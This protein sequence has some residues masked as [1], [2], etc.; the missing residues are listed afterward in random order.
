MKIQE[1]EYRTGLE[2]PSVRFYEK[3]GLLTPKRLENGYRDYS[4]E[5]VE[6]LKKIKLLRRLGMSIEDIRKLQQ[7]SEDLSSAIV[8]QS[9]FHTSQIEDHRRCLAVCNAIREDGAEFSSLDAEHYLTLLREIKI[10]D[11][12]LGRT[13]FQEDVPKELH[14]WRRYF[15][16]CLDY[17][18]WSAIVQFLLFV[19]LRIRPLPGD[20]M[21]VLITIGTMA[22]FVPLEALM[23]HRFGTT[24]G[25]Y[26]TGIRIEYYQGGNLPYAEALERSVQVFIQGTGCGIPVASLGLYV[27]RYCQLTGRSFRRFAR[28][29]QIEGPQDMAWDYQCELI[30]EKQ[31]RSRHI[32]ASVVLALW[33]GLTA[34]TALN[35]FKPQYLGSELTVAQVAKNYNATLALLVENVDHYDKLQEDG[36][37]NPIPSN[38]AVVDLNGSQGDGRMA[39]SYDVQDGCVRSVS[40][41]HSWNSVFQLSPLDRDPYLMACSL[42]LAQEGCGIKE[43]LEFQ[44]LFESHL[45]ASSVS[46]TYN[47]LLI[48]WDIQSPEPMIQGIISGYDHENLEVILDFTVTIQN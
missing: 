42:L 12:A 24:P 25:K 23:L 5:D 41:H 38:T 9:G 29:D 45:N 32:A 28:Y 39:F 40:V 30:Y 33:L 36:I 43:L 21:E 8:R 27:L 15:A 4:E 6:L 44:K 19:V 37:K 20:F 48:S 7:G 14:P 17:L 31:N 10:N 11:H 22:S 3:E 18:L 46:F 35:S 16:R 34:F 26:V 1:L 13:N 2:R 47:N